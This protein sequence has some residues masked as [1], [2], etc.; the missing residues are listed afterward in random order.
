MN[1][2]CA[3]SVELFTNTEFVL[4][5]IYFEMIYQKKCVVTRNNFSKHDFANFSENRYLNWRF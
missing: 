3:T 2:P 1:L 5:L 4:K